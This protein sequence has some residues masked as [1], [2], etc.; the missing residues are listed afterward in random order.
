MHDRV[1]ISRQQTTNRDGSGR[2]PREIRNELSKRYWR[3]AFAGVYTG[4]SDA[5]RAGR[6][7]RAIYVRC[8]GLRATARLSS[9]LSDEGRRLH[10][11]R[12]PAVSVTGEDVSDSR[13]RV[14]D[15]GSEWVRSVEG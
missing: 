13:F 1:P 12:R 15:F 6:I 8:Y 4:R 10:A 9:F 7:Q 5:D 2:E 11:A 14:S 3:N